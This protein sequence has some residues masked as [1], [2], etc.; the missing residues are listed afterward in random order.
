M[1]TVAPSPEASSG[2]RTGGGARGPRRER[3]ALAVPN[4]RLY[5][6][7]AAVA[8]CGG[9]LLRTAQAWLVLDMTG[10][11]AAL[12]LV[13]IAQALPVTILTLFAGV[14]I[15]RTQSR[16]LLV[17]VQVVISVE[18]AVM[19]VLVLSR[20]IQFWHVLVLAVI[21]GIASAI[22]FPTRSSIISELVEPGLVP[23]GV[24]LNSALNSAARI[25]GP[26]VGGLMIAVWGSG[27]CFAVTALIYSTTILGLVR[28]R[29][30]AFYPK[31]LAIRAP[32]LGQL[33]EGLRYSFSTPLLA[34]N[35]LLAGFYG[36]FAYN[37]ALVL[38]L[39]ARFALNSGAEGFGALNMAMGVGSTVGAFLLAT[40]VRA[41]LRLLLLSGLGL[42]SAM[43]VLAHAPNQ[44]VA[45]G[46]LVCTGAL[47]VLFQATNNTLLQIQAREN[48]R[49]RVLSLFTFL[50]IGSTPVGG[51]FTGYVAD[52][53]GVQTALQINAS[54]CLFGLVLAVLFVRRMSR[55]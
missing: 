24:A 42:G 48:I 10:T 13:T 16:K 14:L 49:G 9:W 41:S 27:V 34:V 1:S 15:D 12:A 25:V 31:R 44:L 43:V 2:A 45:V 35:M 8:Q 39:L 4:F 55:A 20:Q 52:A 3:S 21:L 32:I 26:G 18:T 29:G 40:R 33:A 53:T 6:A 22:D 5:F 54:V 30:S 50:T 23:N 28:L 36:T 7:S 19:A 51:A 37:W 11:P 38:P 47:M 17:L 46:V